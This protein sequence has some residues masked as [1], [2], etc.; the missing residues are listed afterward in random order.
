MCITC[1]PGDAH[2]H[3]CCLIPRVAI[4]GRIDLERLYLHLYNHYH[5]SF[6]F[7]SKLFLC[8]QVV[9]LF[10]VLQLSV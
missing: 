8:T 10:T 9:I 2:M 3:A 1:C 4:G 6:I 5:N 7:V